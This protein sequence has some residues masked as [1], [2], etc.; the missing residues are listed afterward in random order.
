M[1]LNR[2]TEI[3][4]LEVEYLNIK[5]KYFSITFL[6]YFRVKRAFNIHVEHYK[7]YIYMSVHI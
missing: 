6:E 2:N 4:M 5:Y 1:Y 7:S 3:L